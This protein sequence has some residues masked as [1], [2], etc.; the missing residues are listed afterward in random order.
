MK[1]SNLLL[2][3]MLA[4][5][6][7]SRRMT[8]RIVPW[9]VAMAGIV[10]AGVA[11]GTS[12]SAATVTT[13]SDEASFTSAL[14]DWWNNEFPGITSS[15]PVSPNPLPLS[16]TTT[17][18]YAYSATATG[19]LYGWAPGTPGPALTTF[20]ANTP[21]VFNSFSPVVSGFGGRFWM[22]DFNDGNFI[23]GDVTLSLLLS[24]NSTPSVT[25]NVTQ[26]TTFMGLIV[27]D[28]NVT[29]TSATL[30]A[31]GSGRVTAAGQVIVGVAVPEP[32][33]IAIALI[34]A[35]GAWVGVRR[36]F[37]RGAVRGIG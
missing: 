18:T 5:L 22:S 27:D 32:Q 33:A 28:P 15:S 10:A 29:I 31:S 26:S 11:P 6:R 16:G 17:G 3:E 35:A 37:G 24:D 34:G 7:I 4:V 36:R 20:A 13:Y 8:G 19:G 21:L 23:A 1:S 2:G 9:L 30:G 12:A 25:T 14:Q